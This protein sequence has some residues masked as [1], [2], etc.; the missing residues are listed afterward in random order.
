MLAYLDIE[1]GNVLSVRRGSG[2]D[3]EL[4]ETHPVSGE[5]LVG[6]QMPNWQAAKDLVTAGHK[7]LPDFNVIGWDVGQ[8]KDGP[9]VIEANANPFHTLY[10]QA[11]G[12]GIKNPDVW[13]NI[14][15]ASEHRKK[16]ASK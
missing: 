12:K 13:P 10:Q 14:E 6:M 1:N 11:T 2:P 8:S 7:L 4:V 5:K 15:R 9:V 3:T 16:Q